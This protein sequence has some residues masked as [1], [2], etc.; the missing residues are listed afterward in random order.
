MRP[1][2]RLGGVAESGS[3]RGER[4]PAPTLNHFANSG[5]YANKRGLAREQTSFDLGRMLWRCYRLSDNER[6][7]VMFGRAS[8]SVLCAGA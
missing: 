5:G 3:R 7:A 1:H 8:E 2:H 6:V 4:R